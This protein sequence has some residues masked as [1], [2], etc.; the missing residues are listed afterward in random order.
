MCSQMGK[1]G[2]GRKEKML[3]MAQLSGGEEKGGPLIYV[4]K[5]FFAR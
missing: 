3:G 1:G 4:G 5:Q 2:G